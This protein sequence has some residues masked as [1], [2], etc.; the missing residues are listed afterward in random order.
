ML[1]D[2]ILKKAPAIHVP[3]EA[4]AVEFENVAF[5]YDQRSPIFKDVSLRIPFGHKAALVGPSGSGYG[6]RQEMSF[7]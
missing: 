2:Y 7:F 3:G 5:G 6:L 4:P 1:P